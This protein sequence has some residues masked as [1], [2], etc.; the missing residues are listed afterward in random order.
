MALTKDEITEITIKR[1]Y[2]LHRSFRVLR[3]LRD[4]NERWYLNYLDFII[5]DENFWDVGE[6]KFFEMYKVYCENRDQQIDES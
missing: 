1:N 2:Y 3:R 4:L 5:S 6:E